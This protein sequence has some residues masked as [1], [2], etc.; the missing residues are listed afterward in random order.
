MSATLK[1]SRNYYILDIP[2]CGSYYCYARDQ[3][4]FH[5]ITR[6]EMLYPTA[7]EIFFLRLILLHKSVMSYQD[8]LSVNGI[9]YNSFQMA[10]VANELLTSIKEVRAIF[11][12]ASITGSGHEIRL[13][14]ALMTL[15]GFPTLIYLD[16]PDI[17][18][19]MTEDYAH[20][21]HIVQSPEGFYNEMLQDISDILQQNGKTLQDFG[22]PLP[23]EIKTEIQRHKLKYGN[24]EVNT[25][26]LGQ[27]QNSIPNT[28]DQDIIWN[29]ISNAISLNDT[30]LYL[31]QAKGGAGKT[32]LAKKLIAFARSLGKIV[33][34]C[35]STGLA[36]TNYDGFETAHSLFCFPV[37]EDSERDESEPPR[38]MFET[39][40]EREELLRCASLIVWDEFFSNHKEIFESAYQSLNRFEGKIVVCLGDIRQ[41]LPVVK[42][43]TV[44][45]QLNSCITSSALWSHFFI[46]TLT[47]NMRLENM[48]ST[49]ERQ[50]SNGI[51]TLEPDLSAYNDDIYVIERQ[52][53][54]GKMITMIGEGRYNDYCG[55]QILEVDNPEKPL[56]IKYMLNQM[57]Y[58][59]DEETALKELYPNGFITSE[60]TSCCII[61]ATNERVDYWNNLVQNM[62]PNQKWNLLSQ[63]QFGEVDDPHGIL[64]NMMT[65]DILNNFGNN[66]VPPHNLELKVGDICIILRNLSVRD[67]LQNNARVRITNISKYKIRVQTVEDRP[68]SS[69][70]PRIMFQFKLPFMQSYT[71]SRLQFPLRLAYSL[72]MNKSQGQTISGRMLL[73]LTQ[74]S[75]THGHLYVALSRITAFYNIMVFCKEDQLYMDHVTVDNYVFRQ[76][77]SSFPQNM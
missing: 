26:I 38:C 69:T 50:Y 41:I 17:R 34:G 53:D 12:D 3:S 51:P 4:T 8:A 42:H 24:I 67:G 10:A 54:Y 14:F 58:V 40:P 28:V 6:M 59:H 16:H 37:V 30:R 61:A 44:S 45:E 33:V 20:C 63:D 9:R 55:A 1:L 5:S 68:R 27:L 22:L 52:R 11:N 23:S 71:I 65:E 60:M 57:P 64:E 25:S 56:Y 13:L 72:T 46:M 31:I 76:L 7:G 2:I 48:I 39:K 74:P 18:R 77:F 75:F 35:A 19:M 62:N 49:F 29:E 36:A 47:T 43:A 21:A 32:T 66:G 15:Q 70:L 73:D